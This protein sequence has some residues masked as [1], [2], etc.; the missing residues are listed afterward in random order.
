ML[1]RKVAMDPASSNDQAL[2]S[3]KVHSQNTFNGS[4]IKTIAQVI[5]LYP[6][7]NENPLIKGEIRHLS[8]PAP[9]NGLR[10]LL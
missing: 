2:T 8:I 5:K 10:G 6:G 3:L 4:D 7:Q 1:E 9:S